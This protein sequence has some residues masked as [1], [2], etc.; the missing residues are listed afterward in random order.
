[1]N[2]FTIVLILTFSL[3]GRKG[4]PWP[5]GPAISGNIVGK[6]TSFADNEQPLQTMNGAKVS[7]D[8]SSYSVLA[9]AD[10]SWKLVAVRA[11]V[12]TLVFSK[13]GFV[14]AKDFNIQFVGS[15]TYSYGTESMGQIP[16]VT[17]T[18]L[19]LV[20]SN[21][22]GIFNIEGKISAA[23]AMSR[24]VGIFFDKTPIKISSI[25]TYL[26]QID[27]YLPADST[28]FSYSIAA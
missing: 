21:S 11:G 9:S 24:N 17:V 12:F 25:M 23:D 10:E 4:D 26:I 18:E 1:M 19:K 28:S 14:T 13:T 3:L 5:A 27:A 22:P 15:G 6:L 16:S 8:G 20:T 2:Y 7:I